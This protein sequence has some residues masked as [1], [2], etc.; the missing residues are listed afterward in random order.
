M[1]RRTLS[2]YLSTNF[3]GGVGSVLRCSLGD[4]TCVMACEYLQTNNATDDRTAGIGSQK[5]ARERIGNS[6]YSGVHEK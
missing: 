6:P 5:R 4:D 1:S 3:Y 2:I